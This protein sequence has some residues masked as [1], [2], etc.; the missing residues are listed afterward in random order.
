MILVDAN[1]M[2][3]AEDRLS[4]FHNKAKQWWDAQLSGITPVCLSWPVVTAFL[5]IA[6]HPRVFRHPLSIDE[7]LNRVQSWL[8]QPC[9]RLIEPTRKHWILLR[10]LLEK[11]QSVSNFV[12]DAHLAALSIEHGCEL[13]S[14]DSD[15]A[16]FPGLKWRNP[17]K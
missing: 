12:S 10:E 4:P 15:F 5:R 11:T 1:I 17:L 9:I 3:Y 2:L 8:D 16:R 14:S 6:T 7:A 13:W